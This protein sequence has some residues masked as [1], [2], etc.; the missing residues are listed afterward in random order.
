MSVSTPTLIT[1]LIYIAAMILIG[2]IAY[3][4]TKNFSDYILG[5]RSLGSFVTALSA[6]ASDMS[7]W[8]LMGLPGAIFVAGLSE[9][10]I[11]IG[12]IIGAWLNWLFVAGRLR[13]H[14][15]HNHNA[16]TLPDYFSHRFEDESRML[17]IFSALVILV[18]FTIYC[19]SGV[20]AGARL[21]ESTFGMPY[22][23]ALWVGA[24][25]TI[26][27]VFIGGFL[28]VSWTDTVQATLMIFALLITPLFVILALGDM[29]TVMATIEAQ[30][31]ANF[32]M[33]RGLSFVAIISL[34][35]WGLGY[36]GQPHILVRFMA[37]DSIKTIPNARRI[38][39]TWMIL[40]LAGAV[41]VGFLGIAYFAD[42]PDQAGAVSQNGERVFMEL[43]KILFNPWVAGIILSGVLAA[44]MSTLSAQLLVS[45][46]AL[47][48]D[49]YK[50]MLR[51]HASQTELVWVG[52]GMVL[53]IALIAIGIASNPESKVLGLVSYAWAG[54]GAAFGPVV[55]I[56]LLWKRMTRNGALVGM[57]VGAVTVVVWKEFIGLGL[58]EI[59][60][61]FI[62]ASIAIVVVSKLGAEP[63]PSIVKR[64]E[65]ADADY[66]A[67]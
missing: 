19:A 28:A 45:S 49:F 24:A 40:T 41:A 55:L 56:S 38:G 58:Y 46:S 59:I 13:V 2:F 53:L 21:F 15:E 52:R 7:G 18:F 32:D 57:L 37:A 31:L 36:F 20:V 16:L 6:G 29:G 12:L 25:A 44:V 14:T 34:L 26:L 17:R 35:A 9:S 67:G 43:V 47:T 23:Y 10:W 65:E 50:A 51:K 48:Q 27:Y 11:A 8:L 30:N 42:H 62:L 1:F 3:R 33:F 66:H 5:G 39:M 63:A 54:F 4:A 64:F 22:E 61:G 60:P